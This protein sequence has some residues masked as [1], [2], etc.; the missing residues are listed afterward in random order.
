MTTCY[1][2]RDNGV[3]GVRDDGRDCVCLRPIRRLLWSLDVLGM[4]NAC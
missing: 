3:V 2:L 1:R 4:R